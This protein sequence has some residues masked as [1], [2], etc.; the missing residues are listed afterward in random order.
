[1]SLKFTSRYASFINCA[2]NG[3]WDSIES[4]EA[5]EFKLYESIFTSRLL[6]CDA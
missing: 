6:H 3:A 1:M 2:Q 5:S 4:I